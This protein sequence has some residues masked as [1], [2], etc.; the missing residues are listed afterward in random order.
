MEN[1]SSRI[2]TTHVGSLVRPPEIRDLMRAK[3]TGQDYD[4]EE[5]AV[6]VTSAVAE[7]VQRQVAEGVDIPSD[8]E[9]GKSGFSVLAELPVKLNPE[10]L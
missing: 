5:L 10:E 1:S 8:G 9:Y 2:L 6:R 3:E 4:R 7:V